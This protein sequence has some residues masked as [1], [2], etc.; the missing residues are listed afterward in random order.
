[1]RLDSSLVKKSIKKA[2]EIMLEPNKLKTKIPE[3]DR[4]GVVIGTQESTLLLRFLHE[5]PDHK[6]ASHALERIISGNDL[7]SIN[8][9]IKGVNAAR[10]I[11]RIHLRNS[12]GETTGYGTGF[13]VAPGVLMTN[14]HVI[15]GPGEAKWAQA[16][17]DYELDISGKEKTSSTFAILDD[18][19]PIANKEL[20]FCMVQ[21]AP[22]SNEGQ[23][24]NLVEYGWLPLNPVPAK[25]IIGE[26]LTIIQ[27]PGGE[28]K[29]VC[30]RENKLL[31]Y[32]TDG[33]T[34]WYATDTVAGSSGSPAFNNSWE[35]VALHHS[36]VPKTDEKGHWLT[37]DGKPYDDS[38]DESRVAWIA[39]EGIRISRIFAYLADSFPDHP[40]AKA[41]LARPVPP[42]ITMR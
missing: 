5:T 12:S 1:M 33:N 8:Y 9:L 11:C 31:R 24:H 27:H 28:R 17:F 13:M 10:S 23:H 34:L 16:E 2:K 21:V 7:T 32:D 40:L 39:N 4:S 19:V 3:D 26:Y 41:V 15:S 29:Q 25:T 30:V 6:G 20:D 37:V 22:S 14:H 18:P 38:M 42:L 35:V 36:G